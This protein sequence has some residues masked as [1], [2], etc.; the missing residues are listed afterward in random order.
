MIN[1]TVRNGSDEFDVYYG[2]PRAALLDLL[3]ERPVAKA[4]EVGTGTGSN[5]AEL[6]RRQPHCRTVGIELRP[7]AAEAARAQVDE[8]LAGSVLDDALC[9]FAPESFDL[10]ILSHVLEHFEQPAIVLR[11]VLGWVAP[12]GRVLV[13]L[14]NV[15]HISVLRELVIDGD[16]RYRSSGLMD[17]THL[18]F[19]TR[20]SA[21][22]LLEE[23]GLLVERVAPEI[24]GT[25]SLLLH[26]LTL[27]QASG[28]TAFAY[29]FLARK[30]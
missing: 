21:M 28:F 6:K 18:R 7:D 30:P 19:F 22:R 4:L 3:G 13:A 12:G 27:G 25:K 29:N 11:R 17:H 2:K 15:R 24:Q 9:S 16:F 8:V 23:Q 10:A 1:D 20:R 26:R 14:P 5:L